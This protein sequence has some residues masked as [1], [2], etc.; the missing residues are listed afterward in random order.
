MICLKLSVKTTI[1]DGAKV[2]SANN[3]A[4]PNLKRNECRRSALYAKLLKV[5]K[6]DM[7]NLGLGCV[8]SR[9]PMA[10]IAK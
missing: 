3:Y 10:V 7:N 1:S 5:F 6:G 4:K 2:C 9:T 8:Y